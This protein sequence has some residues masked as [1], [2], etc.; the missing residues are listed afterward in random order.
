MDHDDNFLWQ[1]IDGTWIPTHWWR[2]GY[3]GCGPFSE[4]EARDFARL[5]EAIE[6][7][8]TNATSNNLLLAQGGDFV[9]PSANAPERI[10]KWNALHP[11]D[12]NTTE[13]RIVV[14]NPKRHRQQSDPERKRSGVR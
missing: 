12:R 5:R 9:K 4:D 14:F 3:G 13:K 2:V 8:K 7:T 6:A 1:G 11:N 10:G